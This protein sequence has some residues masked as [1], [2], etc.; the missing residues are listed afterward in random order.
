[1]IRTGRMD[2]YPR[3]GAYEK[4]EGPE[5]H[6]VPSKI[7][8]LDR[9]LDGGLETGTSCL[10]VGASGVGKSVLASLYVTRMAELGARAAIYS[11]DERPAMYVRR[12]EGLGLSLRKHVEAGTVLLQQLDPGEIAPGEF[13]QNV[14]HEVEERGTKL[15][16]ID[17][18]VGYFAAMGG[19]N[20]LVTQLHELITYLA[21][22]DVLLVMCGSQEG[23][24]SIGVQDAV[25][26][27][28]LSDTIVA[29]T[30]FEAESELRRAIVIV[31][32]KVGDHE[33][34]IHE[35]LIQS[36]HIDV[37]AEPLKE[38]TQLFVDSG[39]GKPGG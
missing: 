31:K 20:V 1:V 35:L 18:I 21:R 28:Y 23:F 8:T 11:F 37:A 33:R 13:A 17:S 4:P 15:V 24:M 9:M 12:A 29:L 26:V 6:V 36:G 19:A 39:R 30:F 27:S 34:K 2:V 16:V 10:I 3:L 5:G 38:P 25:D 32:K 22:S 7:E 14:R